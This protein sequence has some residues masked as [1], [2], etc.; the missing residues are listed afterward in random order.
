VTRTRTPLLLTAMAAIPL[1]TALIVTGAP[2]SASAATRATATPVHKAATKHKKKATPKH[3]KAVAKAKAT[4]K[5][6]PTATPRPTA[7]PTPTPAS[8]QFAGPTVDMRWGPVQVSITVDHGKI[9]DAKASVSP[10]TTRSQLIDNRA[11]PILR[12]EVLQAQSAN[13]DTVSG[14][15]MT[16]E[17]YIRSLQ[18]AMTKAAL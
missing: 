7:T 4:P 3:K 1:S 13:I 15:T 5:P 12:T 16:S 6:K 8:G 18:S 17:A 11:L 2:S 10:D 14:A 9:T